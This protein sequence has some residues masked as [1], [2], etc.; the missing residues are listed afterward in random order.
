MLDKTAKI[1]LTGAAGLV[2]QNL[3]VELKAQGYNNLVAIDKHASNL[4][5]LREL[6]PELGPRLDRFGHE[7]HDIVVD[8][9]ILGHL[10]RVGVM[11]IVLVHPPA[12]A[13]ADEQGGEHPRGPLVP[14]R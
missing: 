4:S 1:V 3:I 11:T 10:V 14:V 2:G 7:G 13:Q 8:V 6:H 9:G 12:V 5:I